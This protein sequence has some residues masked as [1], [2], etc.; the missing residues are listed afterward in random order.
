[1]NV[2]VKIKPITIA[3]YTFGTEILIAFQGRRYCSR[4]NYLVSDTPQQRALQ[5]QLFMKRHNARVAEDHY[6][7]TVEDVR[8]TMAEGARADSI[9][10]FA[11]AGGPPA[12]S[13][14]P[15]LKL[16]ESK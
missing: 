12:Q 16:V 13:G 10:S 6:S 1:M 11:K 4:I 15:A 9:I 3:E 5:A 8:A 2:D 7:A 14:R